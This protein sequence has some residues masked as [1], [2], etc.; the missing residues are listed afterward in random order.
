MSPKNDPKI[1]LSVLQ[2][3]HEKE[4]LQPKQAPEIGKRGRGRPPKVDILSRIT[5]DSVTSAPT[6]PTPYEPQIH[7]PIIQ[8]HVVSENKN[9]HVTSSSTSPSISNL[10]IN[11]INA[12]TSP[13]SKKRK[14]TPKRST[15]ERPHS[16]DSVLPVPDR[17]KRNL[18]QQY[19]AVSAHHTIEPPPTVLATASSLEETYYTESVTPHHP[20]LQLENSNQHQQRIETHLHN[21]TFSTKKTTEQTDNTTITTNNNNHNNTNVN[22]KTNTNRTSPGLNVPPKKRKS[23]RV[24]KG[25][26]EDAEQL[27]QLRGYNKG[28]VRRTNV[29]LNAGDEKITDLKV[30][31]VSKQM[32]EEEER[33]R[34]WEEVQLKESLFET[35]KLML[36]REREQEEARGLTE[37][38][39]QYK[40][41]RFPDPTLKC[42]VTL[43]LVTRA[44]KQ[45]WLEEISRHLAELKQKNEL[46]WNSNSTM[47][48][49]NH[50]YANDFKN[51]LLES[52]EGVE[53]SLSH[54]RSLLSRRTKK[55]NN[56]NNNINEFNS[57]LE[58]TSPSTSLSQP[59]KDRNQNSGIQVKIDCEG[60]GHLRETI[61]TISSSQDD[62]EESEGEELVGELDKKI[63][64]PT[65][66]KVANLAKEL[67]LTEREV[68]AN[69]FPFTRR[70]KKR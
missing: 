42:N 31:L 12:P 67:G 7:A 19:I 52:K 54:P 56:D 68:L 35:G 25:L 57:Y 32:E 24:D 40:G 29:A 26:L 47:N 38:D 70:R 58:D 23:F 62:E 49:S 33:R 37:E 61:Q 3:M 60:N 65:S 50:N 28:R 48:V 9:N 43:V 13:S 18:S 2:R 44:L 66:E 39:L 5:L 22:N 41:Q 69:L 8:Q 53:L 17:M 1:I 14:S 45:F 16:T 51:N 30:G 64:I 4:S 34:K 36:R 10:V 6:L 27:F 20:P 63:E 59:P 21:G 55:K 46:E 15:E 11:R